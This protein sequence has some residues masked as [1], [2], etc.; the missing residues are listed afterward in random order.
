[1]AGKLDPYQKKRDFTKT[2]EPEGQVAKS[3]GPLRF[4]VQLHHA[5]RIHYDFRLEWEGVLLSWAI[6]KGPSSDTRDKRLAVA[7]EDHPLDYGSFEGTIPEDEYGGGTVMLWDEGEW[8]PQDDAAHGLAN[9]SLKIILKGSRLQG[10]WALVKLKGKTKSAKDE[11]NWLLIKEK[12]S[13]ARETNDLA[14]FATSVRTGR[15]IEQIRQGL[16]IGKIEEKNPFAQVDVQLAKLVKTVPEESGWLFELK[17]DGYRILAFVEA[18]QAHLMTR[19][20]QDYTSKF[21]PVADA[22][23]AWAG[24]KTLVLDGEVVIL[25]AQGRTDFQALQNF[26]KNPTGKTLVYTVFDLLALAGADL[27]SCGLTDRKAILETLLRNAPDNIHYSRHTSGDGAASFAAACQAGMEGLIAKKADSIYSGTRNGDWLKIKCENRQ[28]FVVVGFTRTLKKRSGLSAILLGVY[29][30]AKL[31]YAGRA[32]TGFTD[33][34]A[35]EL[36]E[37]FA[38]IA[39]ASPPVLNVP[40]PRPDETVTWLKPMLVAEIRFAEW[41]DQN[42]LRQASFKGLR[43]DK[44]PKQVK[45]EVADDVAKPDLKQ[46]RSAILV[47]KTRLTNPD[48]VIFEDSGITKE[49]VARYYLAMADRILPFAGNRIL[50]ILRCP[51]GL[52]KECFYQKHITQ[53]APGIRTLRVVESGGETGD[54]FCVEGIDGL[55]EAVQMGT[56]EFH[57]WGSQVDHLETP[58]M[59]VFDLDPEEGMSLAN[60]RAGVRSMKEVLDELSLKSFLKTSGGKGYHVVIPVEPAADWETVHDFARLTASLMVQRWPDRFTDNARKEQRKGRIFVDWLRNGRGATSVAPYSI[61]ARKGAPVSMPIAWDELDTWAPNGINMREA[62]TQ[63]AF[64]DP[65][66]DF[67]R[68]DQRI[69]PKDKK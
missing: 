12:D 68:I 53:L 15:T 45:R 59:L 1:M 24:R 13:Y 6:P 23:V 21:Q 66:R 26:I 14:E 31:L 7:V 11:N 9:G 39:S 56:V 48:K 22:L 38:K 41:T 4:V 2:G 58:D 50:S 55:L 17:Y 30:G 57:T 63:A 46:K 42:L 29:D 10:K 35:Q 49:E 51:E 62:L 18:G 8:Q 5:S 16:F 33:Q 60:L 69:K 28:E 40:E 37:K 3:T 32:G 65:W 34:G 54:Y 20:G 19:N 61:R 36:A 67:Y 52:A 47:G 43:T 25:D 44:E 64:T 27:R